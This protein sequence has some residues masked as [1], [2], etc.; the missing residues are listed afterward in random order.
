MRLRGNE[1]QWFSNLGVKLLAL[2]H[3]K[4]DTTA[5]YVLLTGAADG[6]ILVRGCFMFYGRACAFWTLAVIT[7]LAPP[8][9]GQAV[10]STRSGMSIFS[11]ELFTWA[12]NRWNLIQ[13]NFQAYPKVPN[14]A[15]GKVV[16]RCCLRLMSSYA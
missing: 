5:R 14:Y 12:T 16:P 6:Q 13:E 1:T 10:I 9:D 4:H 3:R 11:K 15:R 8:A 7:V 2:Y